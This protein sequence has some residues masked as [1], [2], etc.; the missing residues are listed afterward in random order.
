MRNRAA[1][2]DTTVKSISA[3][4]D[5]SKKVITKHGIAQRATAAGRSIDSALGNDPEYRVYQDAR[6]G[7]AGNLAVLQQGSRPSDADIRAIWL[8]LVPDAFR[9]TDQSAAL[10]WELIYKMSGFT[11]GKTQG[12]GGANIGR[13]RVEVE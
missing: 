1:V 8:P 5:L 3:I 13:F 6:M 10:K 11:P 2:R 7:L 12:S 4:E 9:D